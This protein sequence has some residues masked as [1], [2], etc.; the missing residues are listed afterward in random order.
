MSHDLRADI[1][2]AM[3]EA[4]MNEVK[5]EI[6]RTCIICGLGFRIYSVDD[7]RPIC[8]ECCGRIKY[9]IYKDGE[10]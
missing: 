1:I 6:G 4:K 2:E 9:M 10:P 8:R 7:T 3:N 5:I